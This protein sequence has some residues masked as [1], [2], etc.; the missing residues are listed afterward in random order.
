MNEP[1]INPWIIYLLSISDD[2]KFTLLVLG[3]LTI[4]LCIFFTIL[5]Y[6]DSEKIF[7]KTY[8]AL[9]V[10][11]FCTILSC[12]IPSRDN[13]IIMLIAKETTPNNIKYIV[14]SGHNLKEYF[15]ADF[16]EI[17]QEIDKK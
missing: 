16:I 10:G 9:G 5:I 6:M 2:I 3:L 11:V 14:D 17:L 12:F 4:S 8:I 13:I 7:K 1:L 15:K